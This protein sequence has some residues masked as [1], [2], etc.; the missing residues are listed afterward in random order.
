MPPYLKIGFLPVAGLPKRLVWVGR[1]GRNEVE[2]LIHSLFFAARNK[3]AV[4]EKKERA[5]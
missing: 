1:T 4:T 3:K 2:N 5:G